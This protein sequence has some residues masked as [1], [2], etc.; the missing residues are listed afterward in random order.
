[1]ADAFTAATGDL[2]D[3]MLAALD[4]AEAAGGDI[5]GKQSAA[6]V[7]GYGD[8]DKPWERMFDVGVDDTTDPLGELRRLVRVRRA[9]LG[10][11]RTRTPWATTP[12]CCSGAPLPWPPPGSPTK[13]SR[14]SPR[15]TPPTPAGR[16]SSSASPPPASSPTTPTSPLTPPPE[17]R[18]SSENGGYSS[19]R[20]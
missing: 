2:A 5:R 11:E 6:L 7:V 19:W 9:Y 20:R 12:S 17:D 14:C 16:R 18:Q 8:P 4:A 15:L 13:P 3:R 1:M 10:D